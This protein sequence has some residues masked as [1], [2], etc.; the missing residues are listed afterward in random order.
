MS[1]DLRRQRADILLEE[2]EYLEARE[3]YERDQQ[4]FYNDVSNLVS[5]ITHGAMS[6]GPTAEDIKQNY[7]TYDR[8]LVLE[9][10]H[11]E[12]AGISRRIGRRKF[13]LGMVDGK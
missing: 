5:Y 3:Q 4:V 10:R 13:A 7:P 11:G 12:L 9:G 8:S 2:K 6:Y 1:D